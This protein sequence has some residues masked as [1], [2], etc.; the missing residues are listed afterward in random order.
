VTKARTELEAQ[1][2]HLQ[3]ALVSRAVIDMAKGIV[4]SQ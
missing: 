4:M 3:Q 2:A 1:T